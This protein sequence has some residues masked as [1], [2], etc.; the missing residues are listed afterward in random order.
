MFLA[1]EPTQDSS[2][3]QGHLLQNLSAGPWHLPRNGL[4]YSTKSLDHD[5]V[6]YISYTVH[7]PQYLPLPS[8]CHGVGTTVGTHCSGKKHHLQLTH[9][10]RPPAPPHPPLLMGHL[11]QRPRIF[12]KLGCGTSFLRLRGCLMKSQMQWRRGVSRTKLRICSRGEG[13]SFTFVLSYL[14]P[15]YTVPLVRAVLR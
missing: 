11:F 4:L 13:V 14:E 12:A 5:N 6:R 7:K 1:L 2:V 3:N 9:P 15:S 10:S 8:A